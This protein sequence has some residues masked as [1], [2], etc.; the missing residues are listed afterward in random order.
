MAEI[1]LLLMCLVMVVIFTVSL[2]YH[3]KAQAES[4]CSVS[5]VSRSLLQEMFQQ[6]LFLPD[7]DS[8]TQTWIA[9]NTEY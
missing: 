7:T 2:F 5:P 8:N 1:L 3:S 4:S 9:A 6:H